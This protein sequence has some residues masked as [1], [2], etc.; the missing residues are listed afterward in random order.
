MPTADTFST[1][2]HCQWQKKEATQCITLPRGT[3]KAKPKARITQ[4]R[5]LHFTCFLSDQW[6]LY[7]LIPANHSPT[8]KILICTAGVG[9]H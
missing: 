2:S 1:F 3:E 5:E 7:I 4:K 8:S 6:K 9:W